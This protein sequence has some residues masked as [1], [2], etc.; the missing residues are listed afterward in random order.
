MLIALLALLQAAPDATLAELQRGYDQTCNT[1]IYGQFDDLCS[2]MA[3]RIRAYR[4]EMKRRPKPKPGGNAPPPSPAKPA[5]PQRTAP[6]PDQ[7][8]TPNPVPPTDAATDAPSPTGADSSD[9]LVRA[10]EAVRDT[11]PRDDDHAEIAADD[12][13]GTSLAEELG[14]GSQKPA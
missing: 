5:T 7:A 6:M 14:A 9:S 2:E 1:R 13:G 8:S 12:A 10:F 3:D 11:G 4:R